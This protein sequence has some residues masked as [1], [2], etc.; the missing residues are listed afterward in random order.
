MWDKIQQFF[1]A[2]I[3][4]W[5]AII[6]EAIIPVIIMFITLRSEKKRHRQSLKQQEEEHKIEL[7]A[8]KESARLEVLPIFNLVEMTA[9]E[10]VTILLSQEIKK[11]I[12][13]LRLEN[14][15]NGIAIS[16]FI[17]W[18]D[19]EGVI[20]NHPFDQTDTAYYCRY[21]DIPCENMVAVPGKPIEIQ[22]VRKPKGE[23]IPV[24][25]YFVL[26]IGFCDV[27]GHKYEQRIAV[28]FYIY[29]NG[30]ISVTKISAIVPVLLEND[31]VADHDKE[32]IMDESIRCN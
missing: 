23:D 29:K 9:K 6:V 11:H 24:E 32:G 30:E 15:G 18:N 16:P 22:I 19:I 27:L 28:E 3:H 12:F 8:Q 20:L 31:E 5:I 13:T 10:E 14:V 21:K 2:N 17:K 1:L 26:P 25:D 4:D 7:S